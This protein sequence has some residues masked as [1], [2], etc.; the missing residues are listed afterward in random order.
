MNPKVSFIFSSLVLVAAIMT[1][2]VVTAEAQGTHMTSRNTAL[3]GGGG[4]YIT[5][6]H[7][8]F[9]NPANLM[10]D[11]RGTRITIGVFGGLSTTAGG[12]LANIGVYNEHFTSGQIINSQNA[13]QISDEWFGSGP[14]G[15]RSLGFQVSVVPLG[16][17]YQR[18]N[19]A[20]A[21]ALRVRTM[22]TLSMS[23][24]AFDLGLAGLN[25]DFFGDPRNVNMDNELVAVTEW[26]LGYAMEVW[27]SGGHFRPGSHRVFAG[28][29]P[30]LIFGMGYVRLAMDSR[31]QIQSGENALLVHDFDYYINTTGDLTDDLNA[32]Y[33]ERRVRD[34]QD[35]ELSDFV[36]SDSFS[37]L[38]SGQGFGIGFDLG[39]TYEWYIND[40]DLP[41]IGS[42]PQILRASL[43]FTDI[44]SV[45]FGNNA[46]TFRAMDIF[47]WDGLTVDSD[48]LDQDFDGEFSDYLEHVLEDSIASDIYGNFAPEEISS[49]SMGLN[50]IINAGASLTMNKLEV[51]ADIGTGL[52]SR[53][54]NRNRL[55]LALGAEYNLLS[56]IPIRSG[57]RMGGYAGTSV[58]FGT[59]LN[60]K[61][62][63]FTAAFMNTPGSSSRGANV[64]GA[65]SGL[66]IRF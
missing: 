32:Y 66:V 46:G 1:I 37:D 56:V 6:Y 4:S 29:A 25:S 31:L 39:A 19:M 9:V 7:S 16:V 65:L 36:D 18:D 52:N 3:G 50:P 44:G 51:M 10:L 47:E 8:N 49:H 64:S 12:G 58:S 48:R 53:G 43:S 38:G 21:T 63:E 61:N 13:A 57:V 33:Q 24:G 35:A 22:G 17:H 62:F 45:S 60:L 34:N 55:Y 27:N 41:V 11:E 5:G 26:S 42:G 20:F 2:D 28:I 59:G 23:K 30:K 54:V 14:D 40:I 15:S